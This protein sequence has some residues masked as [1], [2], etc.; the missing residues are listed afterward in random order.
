[1]LFCTARTA[2]PKRLAPA[3]RG[4]CPGSCAIQPLLPRAAI[5]LEIAREIERDTNRLFYTLTG[6][7]FANVEEYFAAAIYF[8]FFQPMSL[9][10]PMPRGKVG[11]PQIDSARV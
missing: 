8:I 5:V 7:H 9:D 1:M 4:F 11:E 2:G 6:W 3:L 10:N